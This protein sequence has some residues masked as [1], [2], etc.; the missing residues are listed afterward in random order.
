MPQP[1]AW[2]GLLV[3]SLALSYDFYTEWLAPRLLSRDWFPGEPDLPPVAGDIDEPTPED[4]RRVVLVGY[5]TGVVILFIAALDAASIETV[6]FPY[7]DLLNKYVVGVLGLA[8]GFMWYSDGQGVVMP[9]HSEVRY[10]LGVLTVVIQL[11]LETCG[12]GLL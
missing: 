10:T 1:L 5:F 4:Y 2:A 9:Y 11:Y 6:C 7:G 3:F 8:T 12:T